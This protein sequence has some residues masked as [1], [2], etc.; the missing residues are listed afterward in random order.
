MDIKI[1]GEYIKEREGL[2]LLEFEDE[3]FLTYKII[4]EECFLKNM[5]VLPLKR[6]SGAGSK[7]I[8]ALS[9]IAKSEGCT[10]LSANIFLNDPGCNNTI[11]SALKFGFSFYRAQNDCVSIVLDL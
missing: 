4:G 2:S 7:F 1:Y 10:H 3:G 5:Y 9:Q 8:R 11:I 6:R